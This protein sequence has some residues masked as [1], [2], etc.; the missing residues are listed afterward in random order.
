MTRHPTIALTIIGAAVALFLVAVIVLASAA[1]QVGTIEVVDGDTVRQGGVSWR[2]MGYDCAETYYARCASERARG[3]AATRR[4]QQLL[5]GAKKVDLIA[6]RQI[7]RYGRQ[8]GHLRVDGRDVGEV[9]VREGLC[10]SYG[11]RGP[12]KEWC[13]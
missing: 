10:V 5:A 3:D 2:L 7:D 8:L 4:L 13:P 1:A 12:R 6:D 9:L 11:G